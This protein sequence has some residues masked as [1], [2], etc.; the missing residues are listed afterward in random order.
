MAKKINF[1]TITD[2]ALEMVS[3]YNV[4][5]KTGKSIRD[6]HSGKIAAAEKA[7]EA[8]L[9]KREKAI[10]DGM[11][12]DE[13]I[14]KYSC[15]KENQAIEVA[16]SNKKDAVS[17]L[18]KKFATG[19]ALVTGDM[20]LAYVSYMSSG[21]IS[22][23]VKA[24]TEFLATLGINTPDVATAKFAEIMAAKVSGDVKASGKA[25]KDG[26]YTQNKREQGFK[27]MF[28]RSFLQILV[29]EKG[30]LDENEE[31][32]ELTRHDFSKDAE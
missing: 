14:R 7:R 1:G 23:F 32:F 15:L 29:K 24:I 22:D 16:K 21:N 30:V 31:T 4:A 12:V 26:N 20:Y 17:A 28:V 19:R 6:Y 27:D 9:E 18:N 11:A 5:Y 3:T 13:A 8:V 10:S 25:L 2:E